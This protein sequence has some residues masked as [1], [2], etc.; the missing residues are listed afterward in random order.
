MPGEGDALGRQGETLACAFLHSQGFRI[1]ARNWR[2]RSGEIDIISAAPDEMIVFVEVKTRRSLTAN[3]LES[4]TP[5]KRDRLITSAHT[6]LSIHDLADCL[7]RFD[8]I[9][10]TIDRRNRVQIE[11]IQDAFDW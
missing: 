10:I 3:P 4:I 5:R 1:L 7:W 2:H 9:A 6:Y 8:V 11:H